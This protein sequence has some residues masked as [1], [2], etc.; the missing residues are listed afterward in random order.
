MA[1][2]SV[3][4]LDEMVLPEVGVSPYAAAMDLVMMSAFAG[5]E[6]TESQW[7]RIIES[8]GLKL[9]KTYVYNATSYESVMDVRLP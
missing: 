5:M 4:L 1:T 8:V 2:D 6:R 7:R 3:I 9:V